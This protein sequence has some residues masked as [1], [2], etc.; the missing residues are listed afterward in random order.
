MNTQVVEQPAQVS[1]LL[2]H[3]NALILD[4]QIG[5]YFPNDRSKLEP[6]TRTRRHDQHILMLI[7][8]INHE[9]LRLSDRVVTLLDLVQLLV[10]AFEVLL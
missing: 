1:T 2:E 10:S 6:M 9:I 7:A 5:H 8:P 4:Q 3:P